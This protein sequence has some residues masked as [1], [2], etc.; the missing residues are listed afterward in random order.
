MFD[1]LP[2]ELSHALSR[3][4]LSLGS[5]GDVRYCSEVAST[6]DV[7]L[8]LASSGATEGTS[9]LADV[10]HKGRGRRGHGWFS[11]PG[12]G[13]YLSVI[14]RPDMTRG[15]LPLLTIGAGVAMAEAVLGSTGLPAELKW[16]NDLVI[17]R[18]W[19]KLGGVLTEAVSAGGRIDA[20]V[21]GLGLNV[22]HARLPTDVAARAS[23]IQAELGRAVDRSALAVELL[24]RMREVMSC[25]HRDLRPTILER[26]RRFA[27]P[28]LGAAVRW[29][30]AR[31]MHRG[32]ARDI[33]DE[34]AL[35]VAARGG[36]ER[37]IAGT[38]S[39]EELSGE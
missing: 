12:A 26:W 6:N 32:V 4:Q 23:S 11:P 5:F 20:V 22:S 17:G 21:V 34:G 2:D 25:V 29:S 19:R 3:A 30:D 39:W 13:L 14:V 38:V 1:P 24:S 37:V 36:L 8:A 35:L 15:A 10:Q 16:P 9:V 18:P 7:A 28:G 33:D 31:G 27:G